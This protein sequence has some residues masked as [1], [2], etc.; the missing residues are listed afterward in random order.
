MCLPVKGSQCCL[1]SRIHGNK[2]QQI[3]LTDL[4]RS[5]VSE[6]LPHMEL[7][8][9]GQNNAQGKWQALPIPCLH[10]KL[11]L[12]SLQQQADNADSGI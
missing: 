10:I 7:L 12:L 4:L 3:H 5:C 9:A 8:Y 11:V 1:H 2:Q 6:R